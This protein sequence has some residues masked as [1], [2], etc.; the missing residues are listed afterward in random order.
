MFVFS[1]YMSM[2]EP[3]RSAKRIGKPPPLR[4]PGFEPIQAAGVMVVVAVHADP[5]GKLDL[6]LRSP[7]GPVNAMGATGHLWR[8]ARVLRLELCQLSVEGGR[9]ITW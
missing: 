3:S 5:A 6:G 4:K 2:T 9:Q 7:V 8:N 1:W